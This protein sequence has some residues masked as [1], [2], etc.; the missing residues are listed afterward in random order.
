[1]VHDTDHSEVPPRP[2]SF[3]LL[4]ERRKELRGIYDAIEVLTDDSTNTRETLERVAALL[5]RAMQYPERAAARIAVDDIA[6]TTS[7]F[8][9]TPQAVCVPIV[10]D[11]QRNGS[12][13]VSYRDDGD[14][15]AAFLAE[16]VDLIE[17]V[18]EVIGL[19]YHHLEI[20]RRQETLERI[21]EMSPAVA[22]I[23]D[24]TKGWPA[25]FVSENVTRFGYT[26]DDFLTDR[27]NYEQVV[28]EDDR[29][30]VAEEVIRYLDAGSD[31]FQQNYRIVTGDGQVR[32]VDDFSKVIRDASG[33]VVQI[34]GIIL[35]VTARVEAQERAEAFARFPRE[36]PAPIFR[37]DRQGD[38]LLANDAGH[39]LLDSIASATDNV[40]KAWRELIAKG[41]EAQTYR[42]WELAVSARHYQ[43]EIVPVAGA[44]YVNL[45]GADVTEA[46]EAQATLADIA[47]NLPGAVMQ[48]ARDAD[49]QDSI[50]YLSEG[51]EKLWGM[52]PAEIGSDPAPLWAM[53]HPDDIGKVKK[54]LS[55]TA[56]SS[57]PWTVDWRMTS[58]SGDSK[59][60]HA[61]GGARPDD[62]GG[63]VWNVL[64]FDITEQKHAEAALTASLKRTVHVLAAALEAHDIYTAGHQKRVSEISVKIG[65][66]MALDADRLEGLELAAA[67][68]DVGKIRVP[69]EILSK[70]GQLSEP[71]FGIIKEH[72][73]VGAEL[74]HDVP[75]SWPIA[76]IVRQHHERY[77]GS[78]YPDGLKGEDI[79]LEARIIAVA[80]TLEAMASH[81]PYRPGLG[82]EAAGE[83]IR[84]G[85]GTRYDPDLAET[86]LRLIDSCEIR[87]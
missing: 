16:E 20:R 3:R 53:M 77:D 85:A 76:D 83:E 13:E 84:N 80:D 46:R 79:L 73:A 8:V 74:I 25:S 41:R 54:A 72:S 45:Y 67:I 60:L 49:D 42:R 18:S 19:Y 78:G 59:V 68:H 15:P 7:H 6:V 23:W 34:E 37:I 51:A 43:F 4:R 63:I 38:V 57:E 61:V 47:S 22:F 14:A 21:V 82:L 56:R 58:K 70:P 11:G 62:Q 10:A 44:E 32:W 65:R 33:E 1:M 81:R 30:R 52:S 66:A 29:A 40:D 5:V 28:H 36:D 24:L 27:V 75:F 31:S 2:H 86:C 12:V 26:A 39:A 64:V 9:Q 17:A 87:V 35:D 69:S 50:R 71:E 55:D 48:Y